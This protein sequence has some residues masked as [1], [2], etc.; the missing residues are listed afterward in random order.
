MTLALSETPFVRVSVF[1]KRSRD[2]F[3]TV[4]MFNGYELFS[5]SSISLISVS[6]N[7]RIVSHMN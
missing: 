6:E 4:V 5:F 2:C 1:R 3:T 7:D